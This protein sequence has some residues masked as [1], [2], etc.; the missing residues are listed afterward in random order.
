MRQAVSYVRRHPHK[1]ID[2][3]LAMIYN[4]KLAE[5]NGFES[6]YT[7]VFDGKWTLDTFAEQATAIYADI[8]GD[9][10]MKPAN[11][12]FGYIQDPASMTNNWLFSCDLLVKKYPTTALLI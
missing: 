11:D 9:G 12:L 8:D 10:T 4:K 5:D 3:T 7:L 2:D 1:R 6:I